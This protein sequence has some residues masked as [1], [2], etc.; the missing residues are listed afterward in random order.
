LTATLRFSFN[1]QFK[2]I[3]VEISILGQCQSFTVPRA[4]AS[5]ALLFTQQTF[6][7]LTGVFVRDN[8]KLVLR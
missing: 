8:K 4:F 5:A 3:N 7:Q 6:L 2:L 1:Y